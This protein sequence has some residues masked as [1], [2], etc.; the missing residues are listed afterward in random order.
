M[1]LADQTDATQNGKQYIIKH[2]GLSSTGVS[3]PRI[4]L[5]FNCFVFLCY[6]QTP[7]QFRLHIPSL[8]CRMAKRWCL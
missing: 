8:K 5:R 7:F 2:V 6:V 3:S 1:Q 4:T